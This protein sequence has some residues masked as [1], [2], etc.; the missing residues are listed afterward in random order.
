LLPF[1]Q[2]ESEQKSKSFPCK[3]GTAEFLT[4]WPVSR[5]AGRNIIRSNFSVKNFLDALDLKTR[6][7]ASLGAVSAGIRGISGEASGE[8]ARR[9]FQRF[10]EA[11]QTFLRLIRAHRFLLPRIPDL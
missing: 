11:C 5:P 10:G 3:N 8:A 6:C 1:F 9:L 7:G 4:G 2:A